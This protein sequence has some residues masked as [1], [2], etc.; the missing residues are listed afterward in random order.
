MK[1]SGET[2]TMYV[3]VDPSTHTINAKIPLENRRYLEVIIKGHTLMNVH[4]FTG[5]ISADL[6]TSYTK[7]RIPNHLVKLLVDVGEAREKA[8][9]ASQFIFMKSRTLDA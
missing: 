7:T 2:N 8:F 6:L 4:I 1:E 5:L 3:C 9:N